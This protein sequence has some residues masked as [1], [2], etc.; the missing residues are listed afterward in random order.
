MFSSR[1]WIAVVG[2]VVGAF[3][4]CEGEK[5]AAVAP[6]PAGVIVAM[7]TQEQ[8]QDYSEFTGALAAVQSVDVR[9]RV[10]GF[11]KKVDFSDGAYVKQGDPLYEIEP[12]ELRATAARKLFSRASR[13]AT[14]VAVPGVIT[15]TTSRRTS[16]L[17]GPGCSIWSQIAI[18]K[19]ARMS[20]A[21]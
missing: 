11:L 19:P 2:V 8:V 14:S 17:P 18:L 9:A 15:R 1:V 12:E 20:R 5:P 10:K 4:G 13:T 16:F 6:V 21:T 3:V 7:P